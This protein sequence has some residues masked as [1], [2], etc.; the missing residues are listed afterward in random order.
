[1]TL[2]Y[3]EVDEKKHVRKYQCFVCGVMFESYN[4][5]KEHIVSEHEE[6][7]D[8]IKCT[9]CDAPVRDLRLHWKVKHP[10]MKMPPSSG[11]TRALVWRDINPKQGGKKQKKPKFREGW[12]ESNKMGK[13]MHYRSGYECTV[14]ECLDA[15]HDI[16]AFEVEPFEIPY[17]FEGETHIYIPDLFVTYVSGVQEIWEIKPANQTMLSKN[18]AKWSAA[19]RVAQARGWQMIVQTEKGIEKMK[20]K[21]KNQRL[22]TENAGT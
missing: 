2:P 1:M 17:V 14:Y 18:K 21:V 7:T 20:K 6:T 16:A 15:D 19:A 9:R 10:G 3:N 12:Y 5:Y 11:P 22:I 8:Y 4:E 13:R